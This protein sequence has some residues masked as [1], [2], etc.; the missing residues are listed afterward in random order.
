MK[1]IRNNDRVEQA[2]PWIGHSPSSWKIWRYKE[3]F[4]ER[5]ERSVNGDESLLSVSANNGVSPRSSVVGRDEYLSRAES[6]VGYKVCYPGDLVM[7]IMLAW[8]RGLGFSKYQGIVSPAY[9]VFSLID[10]FEP[11]FINYLVRTDQNIAY[12]KAFSCGVI[13]SRLRLYPDKFG[14]LYCAVPSTAE[15]TAIAEFLDR[16]TGKIDALIAEQQKLLTL[17]AEKRQATISEAVTRGLR[18]KAKCVNTGI[19][20]LGSVPAHWVV[21]ALNYRYEIALGKMLDEKRISGDFLAQY[22]RNTDVQW[23]AINV[24]NLPQMDFSDADRIRYSLRHNDLLVCE[25]GEVGRA[26]VWRSDLRECFYQKALHRLRPRSVNDI[27]DFLFYVLNAAVALGAFSES[28]N[29]ATI[30]HLPAEAFRRCRFAFPP[31]DEQ[32]SIVKFLNDKTSAL[33]ALSLQAKSAIELL[34]ERRSALI[35]AAV[36]GKIDVRDYIANEEAA[37]N[38]ASIA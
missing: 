12:F 35:S 10:R 6:L 27:T 36:T 38:I 5:D 37:T 8:N 30:A 14:S 26:A 3:I 4:A 32:N 33:D 9:C 25:G 1:L 13:D 11:A 23:G 17:L 2:K 29:K 16:E 34:K 7:N 19:A 20:W 18:S 22:L 28:G 31:L 15:Q 24:E 21:C